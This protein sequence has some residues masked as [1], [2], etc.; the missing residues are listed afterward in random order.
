[1]KQIIVP[2]DFSDTAWNAIGYAIELAKTA[3]AKELVLL[4]TYQEPG[5]GAGDLRD[6]NDILRR[7]SE[8][9]LKLLS[10]QVTDLIGDAPIG[11]VLKSMKGE[12]EECLVHLRKSMTKS[13]VV[14]GT[15]GRTGAIQKWLGSSTSHLLAH[16]D[17]P[18]LVVPPD[19]KFDGVD[20]VILAKD[21]RPVESVVE[22]ELLRFFAQSAA[23]NF[24]VLHVDTPS[25]HGKGE[26]SLGS[27]LP[28]ST[29]V[30]EVHGD[31]VVASI[32]ESAKDLQ[33]GVLILLRR[34]K[35]VL[36]KWL[37]ESV[38]EQIALAPSVPVLVLHVKE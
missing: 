28:A 4:N 33:P 8:K 30:V 18:V 27:F 26:A 1:M 23:S 38:I 37:H 15:V 29:Q 6:L 20:K 35:G 13:L 36:D 11:L 22:H 32:N 7:E 10:N 5:F 34:E 25:E 12:L 14:M 9:D 16:T 19:A 21:L 31:D 24:Q 17:F 2:T 3:G